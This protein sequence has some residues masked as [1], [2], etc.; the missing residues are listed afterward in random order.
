MDSFGARDLA[1]S[2]YVQDPDG[3]TVEL[4]WYPRDGTGR[5]QRVIVPTS[6]CWH[7]THQHRTGRSERG[8]EV[9]ETR[10]DFV[11]FV[12]GHVQGEDAASEQIEV[13][14]L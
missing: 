6:E 7:L 1:V 2:V 8:P 4:R 3:N 13:V 11:Q 12:A 10:P 5:C 9:P 14:L